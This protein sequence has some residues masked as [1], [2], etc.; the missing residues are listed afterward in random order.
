MKAC[1]Y[2]EPINN[3][4]RSLLRDALPKLGMKQ[5]LKGQELRSSG[6]QFEVATPR[7]FEIPPLS[8]GGLTGPQFGVVFAEL[9]FLRSRTCNEAMAES[10]SKKTGAG[11]NGEDL[12]MAAPSVQGLCHNTTNR[13]RA[14]ITHSKRNLF[15]YLR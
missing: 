13:I 4:A 11:N 3:F 14:S 5:G 15:R 6:P 9:L 2:S 8:F 12:A 7:Q 10:A 1:K